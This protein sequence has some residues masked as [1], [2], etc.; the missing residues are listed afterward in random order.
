MSE[1]TLQLFQQIN[2][3]ENFISENNKKID[4]K[5]IS[6][7]LTKTFNSLNYNDN[8]LSP[9]KNKLNKKQLFDPSF[10]LDSDIST[11]IPVDGRILGDYTEW[12]FLQSKSHSIS[13]NHDVNEILDGYYGLRPALKGDDNSQHFTSSSVIC[14]HLLE[15]IVRPDVPAKFLMSG[16]LKATGAE[17]LK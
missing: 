12:S 13:S 15:V 10:E 1:I 17:R 8:N 3:L 11:H 2:N 5:Y 14:T 6:E 16:L 4:E 9:Q 7:T